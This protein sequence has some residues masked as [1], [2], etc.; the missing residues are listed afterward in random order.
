MQ[1]P[2]THEFGSTQPDRFDLITA[3]GLLADSRE[4][5]HETVFM[6]HDAAIGNRATGQIASQILGHLLR[7]AVFERRRFDVR[8]P[9]DG[10]QWFQPVVERG[11]VLQKFPVA[12]EI[13]FA[14]RMQTTQTRQEVFAKL[15]LSSSESQR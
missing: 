3:A 11:F 13:E 14:A 9:R 10:F 8:H 6:R 5:C 4:K 15:D 12:V 1:T 2:A 7:R